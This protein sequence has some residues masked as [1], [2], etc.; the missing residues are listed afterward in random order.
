MTDLTTERL[1][2]LG[3]FTL[4]DMRWFDFSDNPVNGSELH[5]LIAMAKRTVAAER[6]RDALLGQIAAI[7]VEVATRGRTG[8]QC[9]ICD[10]PMALHSD[11]CVWAQARAALAQPTDAGGA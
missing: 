4:Q 2:G 5:A 9:F 7:Q 11:S 10:Q 1:D 6:E 3:A 8:W